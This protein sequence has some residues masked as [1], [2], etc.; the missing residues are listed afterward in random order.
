M[1]PDLG[2][3]ASSMPTE[4][5]DPGWDPWATPQG[6]A[7]QPDPHG[8]G[9]FGTGPSG[10]GSPNAGPNGAGSAGAGPNGSGTR[11]STT[12]GTSTDGPQAAGHAGPRNNAAAPGASGRAP[13]PHHEI[14]WE[15]PLPDDEPPY[16]PDADVSMSDP[17]VDET[18]KSAAELIISELDA[19]VIEEIEHG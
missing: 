5:R 8:T 4:Q 6:D 2:E 9:S 17:N 1:I 7:G 18:G 11:S 3:V 12:D 16:D 15:V 14:R 13:E 10:T 19:E